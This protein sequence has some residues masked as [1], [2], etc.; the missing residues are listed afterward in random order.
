MP[1]DRLLKTATAV[2]FASATLLGCG[3]RR[4]V[5]EAPPPY[6]VRLPEPKPSSEGSLWQASARAAGALVADTSAHSVGDIVT[7]NVVE[8]TT[9]KRENSLETSRSSS[10][11]AKVNSLDVPLP[12]WMPL[13]NGITK[14]FKP[15]ISGTSSRN[16]KNDGKV[17][18]KGDIRTTI[19]AQVAEVLPNGNL[20]LTGTKQLRLGDDVQVITLTGICAPRDIGPNNSVYSS[21]LAETRLQITGSG[22]LNDT[23]RRTLVSRIFDW[24][25]FF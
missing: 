12:N 7:I 9:A 2:I 22:T 6:V 24:V 15:E 3:A 23:Q 13:A 17:E 8:S 19:T 20:L 10:A 16:S 18:D 21:R 14:Q 25:N 11:A 1:K 5:L 4:T